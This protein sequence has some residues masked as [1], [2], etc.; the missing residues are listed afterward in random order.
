MPKAKRAKTQKEVAPLPPPRPLERTKFLDANAQASFDKWVSKG[1]RFS[2]ESE[3]DFEGLGLDEYV[4]FYS[5][6]NL[7]GKP[8]LL[9]NANMVR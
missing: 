3:F 5:W 6:K 2:V 7:A 1:K 4:N 8:K 9:G